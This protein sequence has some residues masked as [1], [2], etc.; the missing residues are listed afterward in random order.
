M[1]IFGKRFDDESIYEFDSTFIGHI[2]FS[3]KQATNVLAAM[4][5]FEKHYFDKWINNEG[6]PSDPMLEYYRDMTFKAQEEEIE[7]VEYFKSEG[8]W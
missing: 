2:T 7:L 5:C 8:L 4:H 6:T 3:G 1:D